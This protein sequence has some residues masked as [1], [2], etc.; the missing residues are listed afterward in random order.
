VGDFLQQ[1]VRHSRYDTAGDV[2]GTVLKRSR[3]DSRRQVS[4]L[5]NG[6]A[7]RRS[8]GVSLVRIWYR[9]AASSV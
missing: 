7:G 8:L 5:H 2:P 1:Q 3:V 9:R 6:D 4:I